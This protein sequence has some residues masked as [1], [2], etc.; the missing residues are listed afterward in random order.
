MSLYIKYRVLCTLVKQ[1][2]IGQ[3]EI[4][5]KDQHFQLLLAEEYGL[6]AWTLQSLDGNVNLYFLTLGDSPTFTERK[7]MD[8]KNKSTIVS[9]YISNEDKNDIEF[10]F[11]LYTDPV[12]EIDKSRIYEEALRSSDD[13]YISSLSVYRIV[14]IIL[15]KGIWLQAL[16]D[17]DTEF[18]ASN[19]NDLYKYL[20]GSG[21]MYITCNILESWELLV[22]SILRAENDPFK[23]I[24]RGMDDHKFT[25][26]NEFECEIYMRCYPPENLDPLEAYRIVENY[27]FDN[28]I[29]PNDYIIMK[30][31]LFEKYNFI[32]T[33]NK[34]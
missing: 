32:I 9:Y 13:P 31:K 20:H 33:S 23:F 21:L 27:Y 25:E 2:A 29:P 1:G 5:A 6:F 11:K 26:F 34:N 8:Y 16:L 17:Y 3:V 30:T 12:D 19:S 24:Y 22:F 18:L 7:L 14:E 15:P 28:D 4:E 10:M